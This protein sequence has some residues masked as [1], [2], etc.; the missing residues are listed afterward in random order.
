LGPTELQAKSS[1]GKQDTQALDTHTVHGLG[2][3]LEFFVYALNRVRCA[4][5]TPIRLWKLV[6][7]QQRFEITFHGRNRV[8]ARCTPPHFERGK[9]SPSALT[10]FGVLH[11]IPTHLEGRLI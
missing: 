10:V 2:S 9:G 8:R 7:Y 6:V 5:C 11:R 4:Q 1:K 3:A